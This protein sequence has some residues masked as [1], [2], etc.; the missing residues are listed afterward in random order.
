MSDDFDYWVDQ[1]SQW[2]DE[3]RSIPALVRQ[4]I[5][6]SRMKIEDPKHGMRSIMHDPLSVQYAMG[7]KDRKYSLTYDVLKRIPH[8]LSMV[9]AILQTRCN[10]V[11][12]FS[13]PYRSSKSIGFMIKHKD[14][15]HLTSK[16]EQQF[17][18]DLETYIYNCGSK[19]PNPYNEN[20]RDDF[21][22]FLKKLV[23][24][25]LMYDQACALAGSWVELADGT[26][27]PI[28]DIQKGMSVRTHT[29]SVKEVLYPTQ[30]L[31]T[32]ELVSLRV[33]GQE[34]TVTANHP[35]YAAKRASA[36]GNA[37]KLHPPEWVAADQLTE[38]MY[39]VYPKRKFGSEYVSLPILNESP[40]KYP[41]GPFAELVTAAGCHPQTAYQILSGI[42]TK[43]GPTKD[44]V[45]QLAESMGVSYQHTRIVES[46]T[47]I[48]ALWGAIVGLYLAEGNCTDNSVRFTFHEDELELVDF[49][50]SFGDQ[51]GVSSTVVEYDRRKAVTVILNST[52]LANFFRAHCGTGSAHKRIPSFVLESPEDVQEAV[53]KYYLLG[54]GCFSGSRASF[55]TVSR[56]LCTGIRSLLSS[57]GIYVSESITKSTDYVSEK[58]YGTRHNS[59]HYRGNISGAEFTSLLR[60]WDMFTGDT[61]RE[62]RLYITDEDNLYVK[63]S[64]V[65]KRAVSDVPVYNLEVADDHS[66]IMQGFVNHNCIEVIPDRRGIPYEFMAVDASTMRIA[67]SNSIYGPN[68]TYHSRS[69][70]YSGQISQAMEKDHGP[71]RALKLYEYEPKDKP[72]FVQVVNGQIEN[73][74]TRDELAFGIR[75]PRSDIYIQ[76]YGYG[77][78]EQLVTIVTAHLYAEE[79]NRRFFQQGSAPKG[80]LTFRGDSM[81]PDQLEGFKR[82]WRATLEGVENAWRTP[83]LQSEQ[84]IEWTDLHPSNREMEYNAWIE[85]LIKITCAVFLID[86]AELNFDLHGGVQQ[87]PLFESS[88]EWKL[89]ASRDRGLK[90]LLRFIAKLIN[91]NIISKI[92]DHFVFDFV[93]LDE[94]TEQEKHTLRTEQVSSYL[95]LNEVRRADDLGDLEYGDIPMN[96]TYIQAMQIKQQMEMQEQQQ[97]QAAPG[98]APPDQQQGGGQEQQPPEADSPEYADTFTKSVS[99]K[100]RDGTKFLEIELDDWFDTI[101]GK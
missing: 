71:Y 55:G 73:V 95:T 85:Y 49:V 66:Y 94:L 62:R 53:L 28:E 75:N 31:Y 70:Y 16:A 13:V 30:R 74:Y 9:A 58:T 93:G 84:G 80:I 98:G 29:G 15:S 61:P 72:E 14:P 90:P 12:A 77:E 87:T 11:A 36:R 65:S 34:L 51:Y 97:Q 42:Y 56:D 100:S 1:V 6:K 83:I 4:D 92:D 17:I 69:S 43:N 20:K 67:A 64:S 57:F 27:C 25:S 37:V 26:G 86:P 47:K 8:Q 52:D 91:E 76:G 40:R 96:P 99:A 78:L 48:D 54:D 101:R 21:E 68:E 44:K 79:Y 32:G 82:Q 41:T 89:K 38:E 46:T 59:T 19:D 3:V 60:K 10:Q 35:V 24:D 33:R 23:R 39:V 81:T 5:V 7:Y 63:I 50:R 45:L 22:T 18:K 2:R 88:Q